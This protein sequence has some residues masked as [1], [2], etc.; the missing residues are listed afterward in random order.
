MN[1]LSVYT[2]HLAVDKL[3]SYSMLLEP[4]VQLI[5]CIPT[6]TQMIFGLGPMRYKTKRQLYS[7][8]DALY[9]M[10]LQHEICQFLEAIVGIR[11]TR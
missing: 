10:F 4:L 2:D 5:Y 9:I 11:F 7:V 3:E 6:G 1:I 8:D